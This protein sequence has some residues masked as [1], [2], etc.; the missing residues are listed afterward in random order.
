MRASTFFLSL[1]LLASTWVPTVALAQSSSPPVI[2]PPAAMSQAPKKTTLSSSERKTIASE[3]KTKWWPAANSRPGGAVRWARLLA[4]AVATADAEFVLRATTARTLD[5][6]HKAL[7]GGDISQSRAADAPATDGLG[8][9]V[10]PRGFLGESYDADLAYTPLPNGSVKVFKYGK[11]PQT[12]NTV[13]MNAGTSGSGGDVTVSNCHGCDFDIGV[14]SQTAV[15]VAI[16][17]IGYYRYV[18]VRRPFQP[19]CTVTAYSSTPLAANSFGDAYPP[20]CDPGYT[21]MSTDCWMG[22]YTA[23]LSGVFVGRCYGSAGNFASSINAR[24]VC[25]NLAGR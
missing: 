3:L 8:N 18:S 24:N 10:A 11:A 9:G 2:V 15:H 13:W 1:G 16:D 25:C 4:T 5:D 17:V 22:H 6:L 20:P 14:T 12:G 7:A 21:A 23:N 19:Y